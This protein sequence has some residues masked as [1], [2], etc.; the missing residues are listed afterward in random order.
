MSYTLCILTAERRNT[1]WKE[2]GKKWEENSRLTCWR[3]LQRKGNLWVFILR[4]RWRRVEERALKE[5][6]KMLTWLM[7]APGGLAKQVQ[8]VLVIPGLLSI[9]IS[10]P[11]FLY[12]PTCCWSVSWTEKPQSKWVTFWGQSLNSAP[13]LPPFFRQYEGRKT[14]SDDKCL[15]F[16]LNCEWTHCKKKKKKEHAWHTHV[17]MCFLNMAQHYWNIQNKLCTYLQSVCECLCVK[18]NPCSFKIIYFLC[19]QL[20]FCSP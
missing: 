4:W 2:G 3:I 17:P 16:P 6:A 7:L 8:A 20:Y 19:F 1:R 11:P 14:K 10:S 13:H 12:F 18:T 5:K 15:S 9:F